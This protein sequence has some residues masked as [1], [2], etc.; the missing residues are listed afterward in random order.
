[1]DIK[2]LEERR[3]MRA[4][5][6]KVTDIPCSNCGRP[7]IKDEFVL[8]FR[9]MCDNHECSLFREGQ[10]LELKEVIKPKKARKFTLNDERYNEQ[11]R[12]NYQ[13]LCALGVKTVLTRALTGN[14]Q[15]ER[16]RRMFRRGLSA[17]FVNK[18][19]AGKYDN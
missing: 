17:E 2:T 10:G 6:C 19:L 7:L 16:V 12:A 4:G 3:V 18:A 15:T 11:R 9:L 14:K 8:G 1:M 13:E 5:P